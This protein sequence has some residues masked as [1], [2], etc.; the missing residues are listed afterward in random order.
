M[1]LISE[2][3]I[4]SLLPA[5]SPGRLEASGVIAV[6]DHYLV[7]FDNLRTVA[8][9]AA[10]PPAATDLVETAPGPSDGYEDIARDPLTGHIYLLVESARRNGGHQARVEEY[11]EKLVFLD[12]AWLEYPIAR[13]NKGME[14]LEVVRR[15]GVPYLL[16]L[17]EEEGPMVFRRGRRNWHPEARMDIPGLADYAAVA[18]AGDRLAVVS[19]ESAALWTGH[20][21]PAAW[22][23]DAGRIDHFPRGYC[24]VE[25]VAWIA[26]DRVVT[27]SDRAKRDSQP[28]YCQVEEECLQI[29]D[30]AR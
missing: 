2:T 7:I 22:S 20:L 8:R 5:G 19:Q 28:A 9:I 29:F 21:D 24:T 1:R 17:H 6:D 23:V 15:D 27:V 16:T 26:P 13:P 18:L 11:D 3:R 10:G 4:R 12:A 25:G 14:G 30:L